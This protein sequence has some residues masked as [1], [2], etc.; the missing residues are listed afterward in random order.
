MVR[1]VTD[2]IRINSINIKIVN[3]IKVFLKIHTDT[4]D[5]RLKK[6]NCSNNITFLYLILIK[7]VNLYF[8]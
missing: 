5:Y 7:I 6:S 1:Y 4:K 2:D 3:T 8:P